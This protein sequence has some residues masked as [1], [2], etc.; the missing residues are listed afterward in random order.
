MLRI[1]TISAL[2][3]PLASPLTIPPPSPKP[4]NP[5]DLQI[6]SGP[7]LVSQLQTLRQNFSSSISEANDFSDFLQ[8]NNQNT[9]F[10]E[11]VINDLRGTRRSIRTVITSANANSD[12]DE[13]VTNQLNLLLN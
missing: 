6:V 4:Q 13:A 5:R 10:I 8:Q 2:C 12:G 3:L 1:L 9:F 11:Q 7:M